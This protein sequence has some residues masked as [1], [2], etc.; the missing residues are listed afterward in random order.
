MGKDF[1]NELDTLF[2]RDDL[3]TKEIEVV[4]DAD[5]TLFCDEEML[6]NL[7]KGVPTT[8]RVCGGEHVF[9]FKAEGVPELTRRV[10]IG[11]APVKISAEGLSSVEVQPQAEKEEKKEKVDRIRNAELIAKFIIYCLLFFAVFLFIAG[12]VTGI[13]ELIESIF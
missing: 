4:A 11:D 3:L 7:S 2:D 9:V 5:C 8:L 12:I 6:L 13:V 1:N 10:D